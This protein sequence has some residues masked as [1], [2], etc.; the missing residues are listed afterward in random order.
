MISI[1]SKASLKKDWLKP[2]E[3]KA[4]QDLPTFLQGIPDQR[5]PSR[6]YQQCGK[7]HLPPHLHAK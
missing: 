1:A 7:I 3:E 6:P 5:K 2:E 4:W